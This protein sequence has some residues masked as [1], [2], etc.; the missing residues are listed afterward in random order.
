MILSLISSDSLY[1]FGPNMNPA[2]CPILKSWIRISFNN[3]YNTITLSQPAL[4]SIFGSFLRNFNAYIRLECLGAVG[5]P[6]KIVGGDFFP[7]SYA[8][9]GNYTQ[10][11]SVA[12]LWGTLI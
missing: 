8:A 4:K 1:T 6:S 12:S 11:S 3:I 2:V 10:V 9:T 5:F 7:T